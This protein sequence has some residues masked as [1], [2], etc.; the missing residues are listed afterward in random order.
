MVNIFIF[1]FFMEWGSQM[2]YLIRTPCHLVKVFLW[3]LVSH[4]P[5]L[6]KQQD[7]PY[8]SVM[9]GVLSGLI[10]THGSGH[11]KRQVDAVVAVNGYHRHRKIDQL[12]F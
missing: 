7:N 10:S 2:Y 1:Y 12:L 3:R 5:L 9:H 11:R 8:I 6:T 4:Q